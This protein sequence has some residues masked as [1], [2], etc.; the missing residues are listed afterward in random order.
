MNHQ[1]ESKVRRKARLK[2]VEQPD[3]TIGCGKLCKDL[4]ESLKQLT[5]LCQA[6]GCRGTTTSSQVGIR[7]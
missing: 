4:R 7:S 3:I 2:R 1:K 6:S 5:E